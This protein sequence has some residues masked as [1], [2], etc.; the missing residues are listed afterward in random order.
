MQRSCIQ[1]PH[2]ELACRPAIEDRDHY[3]PVLAQEFDV[4][5]ACVDDTTPDL[6]AVCQLEPGAAPLAASLRDLP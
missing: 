2:L 5:P 4:G 1:L 6:T 3:G